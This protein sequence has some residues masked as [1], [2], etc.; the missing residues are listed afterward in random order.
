MVLGNLGICKRLYVITLV[1][2]LSSDARQSPVHPLTPQIPHRY[3]RKKTVINIGLILKM[4]YF[5]VL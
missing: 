2:V 5:G 1:L 4:D 3:T